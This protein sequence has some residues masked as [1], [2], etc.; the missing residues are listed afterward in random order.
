MYILISLLPRC[1]Y[2]P[3]IYETCLST[4]RFRFFSFLFCVF[5]VPFNNALAYGLH[6]ACCLYEIA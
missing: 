5:S 1:T 4:A 3:K 2:K 6:R